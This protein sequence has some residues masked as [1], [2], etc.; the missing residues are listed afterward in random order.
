MGFISRMI[1]KGHIKISGLDIFVIL[2]FDSLIWCHHL[3]HLKKGGGPIAHSPEPPS[4]FQ[5]SREMLNCYIFGLPSLVSLA[6]YS[7]LPEAKRI[8]THNGG[9]WPH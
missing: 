6:A 2:S 5:K 4:V 9:G 7:K 1:E 3:T 8:R